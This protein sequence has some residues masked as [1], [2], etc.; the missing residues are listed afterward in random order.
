M[1]TDLLLLL[2]SGPGVQQGVQCFFDYPFMP[3]TTIN[4]VQHVPTA[5]DI[6]DITIFIPGTNCLHA[7][8][9]SLLLQCLLS[10]VC[11]I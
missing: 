11:A 2:Y 6:K 4:D 10:G 7:N 3:V 1:Q 8:P 9:W 5:G